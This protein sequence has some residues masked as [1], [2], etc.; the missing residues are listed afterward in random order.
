MPTELTHRE[1]FLRS[2]AYGDIDRPALFHRAEPQLDAKLRRALGLAADADLPEYFGSDAAGAPVIRSRRYYGDGMDSD[3]CWT[4]LYGNRFKSVQ[5]GELSSSA[6]VKPVL[7]AADDLEDI[8]RLIRW[9][10]RDYVDIPESQAAA[11]AA[12]ATG[13]AVYGG[14]WASLFTIARSIMG[15]EHF[16]IST[17]DNPEFVERLVERLADFFIACNDVYFKA[18]GDCIDVF[19][20]GSDFG[21]QASM[22]IGPSAF[23]RFFAGPMKRLCDHAKGF[24]LKV[25]Y[26]TC[27]AVAPIVPDLVACGVDILD[28]VQVSAA[29][30]SPSSLASAFKGKIAF[31]GGISTQTTLPF[32]TIEDVRQETIRAIEAFGPLGYIAAPDQDMIGDVPAGNIVEM[33]KVIREYKL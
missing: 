6:V 16:L 14:M 8:E 3:G 1:R 11:R 15:E 21:T 26:H 17:L 27:G 13:R 2:I 24:G 33:Y 12:R 9:P 7:G 18:C 28:P 32:G 4:D 25:M 22:F 31:H 30:M 20:F 23:R 19:Y 10:G 29:G 5:Y